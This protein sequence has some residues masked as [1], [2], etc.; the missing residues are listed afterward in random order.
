MFFADY[1][2]QPIVFNIY[3]S[4]L[5]IKATTESSFIDLGIG[6]RGYSSSFFF[7]A[8]GYYALKNPSKWDLIYEANGKTIN[9]SV[10]S[11]N[12]CKNYFGIYAELGLAFF[13]TEVVSF[14]ISA[15]YKMGLTPAVDDSSDGFKDKW[16]TSA[17]NLNIGLSFLY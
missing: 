11:E 1:S 4:S 6:I 10:P 5:N 15:K 17:L 2:K 8:G 12:Y 13:I 14:D 16:T 9:A 3:S 7:G